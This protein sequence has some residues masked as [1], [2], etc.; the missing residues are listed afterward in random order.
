MR[1][2]PDMSDNESVAELAAI[3]ID[4]PDPA[5]LAVFYAGALGGKIIR[6][7]TDSH[8]IDAAGTK[9]V[10]R[11]VDD[12]KAPTWPSPAVP[13]QLHFEFS[14]DDVVEAEARLQRLGATT[15]GYQPGADTGLLVLLDPAGH[16]FCIF[17][18][19]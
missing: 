16:P 12:H 14:V 6:E 3:T 11:R 4:C 9:I 13:M 15:P 2:D 17:A 10:C 1:E 18:R 8:I 19:P 7:G 5:T